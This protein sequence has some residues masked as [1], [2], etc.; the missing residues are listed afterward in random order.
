[1]TIKN[2]INEEYQP[3]TRKINQESQPG[4]AWFSY[5]INQEYPVPLCPLFGPKDLVV[6]CVGGGSNAIG[7]FSAFLEDKEAQ[8]RYTQ[9]GW[10]VRL[11][12]GSSS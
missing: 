9:Q 2:I 1:M 8:R 7:M 4:M 5:K 11:G 3:A 12:C 10:M 6:A